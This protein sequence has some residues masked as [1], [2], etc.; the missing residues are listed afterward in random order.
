MSADIQHM[1]INLGRLHALVTKQFLYGPDIV[2]VFE[3]VG[4][5]TVAEGMTARMLRDAGRLYRAFD[6]PLQRLRIKMVSADHPG[7]RVFRS[8]RLR[9]DVL[10]GGLFCGVRVFS[11]EGVREIDFSEAVREILSV[12]IFDAFYLTL[13]AIHSTFGQKGGAIHIPLAGAYH[14]LLLSEIQILHAQAHALGQPQPGTVKQRSH[15]PMDAIETVQYSLHLRS[16]ED[17]GQPFRSFRPGDVP[18][19]A[20]IP[21]QH[22]A[23]QEHQRVQR[24]VLRTGGDATFFGQVRQELLHFRCP[25]VFRMAFI[26]KEYEAFGPGGIRLFRPQTVVP[27]P[28]FGAE[29]IQQFRRGGRHKEVPGNG[30]ATN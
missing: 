27:R 10:P 8:I 18:H 14:D 16:G 15:Q 28:Y 30:M 2:A 6:G 1:R 23:I 11:V 3:Q 9:K 13:Q 12:K 7:T 20:Q 21:V 19:L 24:L 22:P 25:H 5:E 17:N 29:L 4:G 26:V